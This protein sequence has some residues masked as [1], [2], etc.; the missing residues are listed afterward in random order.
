MKKKKKLDTN[1]GTACVYATNKPENAYRHKMDNFDLFLRYSRAC[2]K[3][4]V[5]REFTVP[6]MVG[7][8]SFSNAIGPVNGHDENYY[9]AVGFKENSEYYPPEK[10][11]EEA[12]A[13][14]SEM[15]VKI[16]QFNIRLPNEEFVEKA[17]ISNN[18]FF[19]HI[20][21]HFSKLELTALES[22]LKEQSLQN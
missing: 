9:Y 13:D 10:L 21:K 14:I 6:A 15:L 4:V 22:F 2:E 20:E 7:G 5:V 3:N 17:L 12:I 19:E 18:H 16:E 11:P 1:N 8:G